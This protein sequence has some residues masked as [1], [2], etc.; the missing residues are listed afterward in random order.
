MPLK[1]VVVTE[2]TLVIVFVDQS[3]V[4]ELVPELVNVG[5]VEAIEALTEDKLNNWAL[6]LHMGHQLSQFLVMVL[7]VLMVVVAV[8]IESDPPFLGVMQIKLI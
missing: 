4:D 1:L 5:V 3:G 8:V 2:K 7:V 6:G